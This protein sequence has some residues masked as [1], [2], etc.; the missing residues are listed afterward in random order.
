M[1]DGAGAVVGLLLRPW[2]GQWIN[3]FG[4]RAT[5]LVG[6]AGFAF[7]SIGNL[8]LDDLSPMIYVLRSCL[9]LGAAIVFASSVT[10][11]T[12]IAPPAR[13]T[14]AIGLIGAGGFL[15]MLL[16]PVLGDIQNF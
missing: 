1:G 5:W 13:R 11:I 15:G 8:A 6:Q 3:R 10:Y 9:V 4:P 14:E 2:I 16:G 7:G 12:Q